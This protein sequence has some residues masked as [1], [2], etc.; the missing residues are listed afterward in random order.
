MMATGEGKVGLLVLSASPGEEIVSAAAEA[1][2]KAN[3]SFAWIVAR[4]TLRE[5]MVAQGPGESAPIRVLTGP[6]EITSASGSY[7]AGDAS[8][9]LTAVVTGAAVETTGGRFAMAVAEDV[10]LICFVASPTASKPASARAPVVAEAA[11]TSPQTPSP[12]PSTPSAG[13]PIALG[14]SSLPSVPT[15]APSDPGFPAL[16]STPVASTIPQKLAR[17]VEVEATN[18]IEPEAGDTVT[19]F[20][21]GECDVETSD[22]DR[23][24]LRQRKDDRVREVS[25]EM[26]RIE[27]PTVGADGKRHFKLSRKN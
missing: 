15:D 1:L 18:T 23:I 22:G 11:V 5:A 3:V 20:A 9:D 4:G 24:R 8:I 2:A 10:E 26:L 21:F 14:P 7:R 19:H 17:R 12:A 13:M 16:A 6:L 27:A 25:L